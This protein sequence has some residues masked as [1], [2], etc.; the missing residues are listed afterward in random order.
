MVQ[1]QENDFVFANIEESEEDYA[2]TDVQND[3]QI[4]EEWQEEDVHKLLKIYVDNLENI[5]S[6]TTTNQRLWEVACRTIF[7]DKDPTLCEIGLLS[8]KQKY[9]EILANYQKTGVFEEWPYNDLCHQAFQNDY[10]VKEFVN[11]SIKDKEIKTKTNDTKI[12]ED[13]VLI[14][15][16]QA[17]NR[18]SKN[19][20]DEKVEQMLNLYLKYKDVYHKKSYNR[21]FWNKIAMEMGKED[22]EYWQ[23][24]FLNF[25]QHYIRMLHRRY[26][27]GPEK[28][29]WPYM[30]MF[31]QIFEGDER[32]K[33][34]Y[35]ATSLDETNY[36]EDK[37]FNET[38]QTVLVKYCFDCFHEFQDT[39]IPNK[40]LWHEIGR[41]LEKNPELC[42]EKYKEMKTEH[43]KTLMEGE[44]DVANRI[45]S[46]IIL[47]NIIAR[48]ND[49][50]LKKHS[51]NEESGTWSI[52]K[53]DE[54][55]QF[56]YDN[57]ELFKD[58]VCYY[59]CWSM[60][61]EKLQKNMYSCK[62]QWE[63]LT[64]LYKSIL[65]DKK[66]NPDMQINWKYI[67]VFD[68]IFDYG[69]DTDLLEG[70]ENVKVNEKL[71]SEKIGGK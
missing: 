51:K 27:V 62:K 69:M 71:V 40:F 6:G 24:R 31:D 43:F 65:E 17:T 63:K 59:V 48:E 36:K 14:L 47:D 10:Y 19:P 56:F 5:Q 3:G 25:K 28:I 29:N 32:F 13:G 38:E 46:A 11:E 55:V 1:F 50:E 8:L 7:R 54:L 70:Y 20:I 39:T 30:K 35:A 61:A 16:K 33:N 15:N 45:P 34:K 67:D 58:S 2:L 42:K 22:A 4:N 9:A 64:A 53:T 49:I 60:V 23:K 66:E 26:E 57:I 44:Y 21:G 68:R 12:N 37:N 52:G 41:L 18:T